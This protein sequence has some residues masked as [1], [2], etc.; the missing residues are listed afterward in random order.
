MT[1][2]LYSTDS[3]VAWC[4]GKCPPYLR[5]R[6]PVPATHPANDFARHG[7]SNPGIW[8][9]ANQPDGQISKS[10]S[11]PSGKN[12]SLLLSGK[13]AL[14]LPPSRPTR[15]AIARRHERGA[16]CGGRGSVRRANASRTNDA[17]AYGQVVSFWRPNAGVKSA[18]RSAGDGVKQAWSPGRARSKP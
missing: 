12:S 1:S 13:S 8:A 17:D 2:I 10:L 11:S 7:K 9:A 18:I 3:A 16:G 6:H 4:F 14:G 5:T 15:G